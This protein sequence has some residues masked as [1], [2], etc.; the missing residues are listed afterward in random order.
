MP[1]RHRPPLDIA[2]QLAQAAYRARRPSHSQRS[3]GRVAR[4]S[5]ST[6]ARIEA[7]LAAGCPAGDRFRVPTLYA[8]AHAVAYLEE[9]ADDFRAKLDE[10]ARQWPARD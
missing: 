5:N 8:Y 1:T 10:V 6:I 2:T 7:W 9:A 3:I 4:L